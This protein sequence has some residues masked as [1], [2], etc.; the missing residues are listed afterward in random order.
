MEKQAIAAAFSAASM[1]RS[2]KLDAAALGEGATVEVTGTREGSEVLLVELEEAVTTAVDMKVVK[3]VRVVEEGVEEMLVVEG[4]V[5]TTT[6]VVAV[7]LAGP[8]VEIIVRGFVTPIPRDLEVESLE[9]PC[10]CLA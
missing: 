9:E 1:G 2:L 5:V 10:C 7:W 3:D 6:V 8:T 4:V